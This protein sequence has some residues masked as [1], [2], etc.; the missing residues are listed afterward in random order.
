MSVGRMRLPFLLKLCMYSFCSRSRIIIENNF[1]FEILYLF[2]SG[3]RSLL[4]MLP[5]KVYLDIFQ[6]PTLNLFALLTMYVQFTCCL[7]YL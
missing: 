4:I 7:A 6:R 5:E 3:L 1:H 2:F